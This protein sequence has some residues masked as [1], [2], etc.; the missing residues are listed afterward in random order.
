MEVKPGYKKTEVGVIPEE[1][2]VSPVR[3]K[4]EV[5]TGKALAVNAPGRQRPYLR[6]KN[7]FDGRIEIDDVLTM[8]MTE[9]QFAQFRIR[10]GDVL[11]NE[12]QSIELVGRCAMYQDEYP[13]PCAIQNA[14]L[15]FRARAGVSEKFASYLFR[16]CQ[17]TGVFARIALQTTSV[18]HLGGSRFERLRLAWPTEPEQRAIAEALSDVD[19]LLGGLDR[20]I[21]KKRDLKQ[22]AM[23]QLLTGQTR[24]PGFH[25]EWEVKR[26]GE[27]CRITTGKKDVNEGNPDGQFPFFTCSRSHTFSD[28]YSFDTEA[29]LIAGN[30]EVG[31]LHYIN[32]K[33]EAYQR[34]Y[35]L[36]AFSAH[37]RY[38]WQQLSAYLADSLGLG[39][40]GSSIPYIK[41]ENLSGFEF[42]SPREPAEQT[43]IATVLSEMDGELAVLE[44]RRE[45]TR[46]L[47]QALM[48]ELL[49]GRTRLVGRSDG[50]DGSDGS[51]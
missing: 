26:L 51:V 32:G 29:I 21:A 2:D 16:H 37:V 43:A 8:P 34:T 44:Q 35:V 50:S 1:W 23:Q 9:E 20:L 10:N 42:N 48:Q 15:R 19:G 14:L 3:Q 45:K 49:T 33:F 31:N 24:L 27:V 40:I 11:L 18:A 4:G 47:K 13:E 5:L 41:K 22:A 25:G 39:K 38:L 28:S 36:C 30:G 46:A 6:T 7:V 17:H 12:G